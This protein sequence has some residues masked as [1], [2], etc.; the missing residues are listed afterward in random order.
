MKLYLSI[1]VGLIYFLFPRFSF[2]YEAICTFEYGLVNS[3]TF[4][5][6]VNQGMLTQRFKPDTFGNTSIPAKTS[7]YK[8]KNKIDDI[9]CYQRGNEYSG[10]QFDYGLMCVGKFDDGKFPL[11]LMGHD[12]TAYGTCTLRDQSTNRPTRGQA[13]EDKGIHVPEAASVNGFIALS[14]SSMNWIDAIA[15][16]QRQ[17]GRLP[18]INNSDSLPLGNVPIVQVERYFDSSSIDGF[19]TSHRLW[20]EVGLPTPASYWTGTV[21]SS[22]HPSLDGQ[23]YIVGGLGGVSIHGPAHTSSFYRVAC[24]P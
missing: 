3:G 14:D 6:S 17:G 9:F 8:F 10:G 12:G 5:I 22:S 2:A 7:V 24:V 21:I 20:S 13:H 4:E 19:G 15:W 23:V 18:R 11:S 16:C 1:F